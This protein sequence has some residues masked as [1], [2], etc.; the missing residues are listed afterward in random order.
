MAQHYQFVSSEFEEEMVRM[1]FKYYFQ[2]NI[3]RQ[4][5]L[6]KDAYTGS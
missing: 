3:K 2:Q 5:S 6:Y 4:V 1:V